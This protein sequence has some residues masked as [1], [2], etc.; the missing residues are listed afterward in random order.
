MHAGFDTAAANADAW[1]LQSA[2]TSNFGNDS[3]LK[4]DIAKGGFG[5]GL[6]GWLLGEP[7]R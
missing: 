6:G 2:P 1:V 7:E 4:Q 5:G 3:V